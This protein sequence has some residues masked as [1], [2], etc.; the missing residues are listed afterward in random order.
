MRTPL[1]IIM[2]LLEDLRYAL[3]K[4]QESELKQ[5]MFGEMSAP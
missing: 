2:Q 5:G 3:P 4:N 1:G